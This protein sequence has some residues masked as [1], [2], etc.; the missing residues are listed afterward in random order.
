MLERAAKGS[1]KVGI[2]TVLGSCCHCSPANIHLTKASLSKL[3]LHYVYR[4]PS[5][6]TLHPRHK[7]SPCASVF[8]HLLMARDCHR[9][10][11]P[12]WM[13]RCFITLSSGDDP[14]TAEGCLAQVLMA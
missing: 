7:F 14:E 12:D 10:G 5:Y 8:I 1:H 3:P 11:E 4:R 13:P 9:Q 2:G 6:L